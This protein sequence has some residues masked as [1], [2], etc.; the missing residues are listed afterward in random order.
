[1][2][3]PPPVLTC[4]FCSDATVPAFLKSPAGQALAGDLLVECGLNQALSYVLNLE[5][6]P[7]YP[8]VS[9]LLGGIDPSAL[10]H[11]SDLLPVPIILA[12]GTM[13]SGVALRTALTLLR[14]PDDRLKAVTLLVPIADARSLGAVLAIADRYAIAWNAT[15]YPHEEL[16]EF[17]RWL[18][19]EQLLTA[20]N[21]SGLYPYAVEPVDA[22]HA[23]KLAA[24][25][26]PLAAR[27]P[28]FR[29]EIAAVAP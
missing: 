1:M 28:G 15:A 11:A 21:F 23:Q 27:A 29:T 10:A 20:D 12:A 14:R 8:G 5:T 6:P 4:L 26:A 16:L 19:T 7:A 24:L 22:A 3:L 25:L 17:A 2:S 13:G 9:G 18:A